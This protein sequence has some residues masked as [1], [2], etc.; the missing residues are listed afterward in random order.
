MVQAPLSGP[1]SAP[2]NTSGGGPSA[3]V[4]AEI[5]GWNWGAFLLNWIW[6]AVH[7]AWLGLVLSLFLGIVGGIVC[8]LK[9]N[10]WAWQNN[11]YRSIEHFRES[12]AT[13]TKWGVIILVVGFGLGVLG[14]IISVLAVVATNR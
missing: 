5:Q 6:A 13:W 4:P 1:P 8:G 9:G 7:K 2:E 3:V 11:R 12:Q 14:A 10:E